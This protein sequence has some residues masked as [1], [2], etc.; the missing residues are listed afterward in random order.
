[1]V[2]YNTQAPEPLCQA[3]DYTRDETTYKAAERPMLRS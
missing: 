3:K 2:V 1:M